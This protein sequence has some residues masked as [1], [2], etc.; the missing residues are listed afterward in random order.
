M[1]IISHST[2]STEKMFTNLIMEFPEDSNSGSMNPHHDA[3]VISLQV[4]NFMIKRVLVDTGSSAN[5]IFAAALADMGAELE[6][7]NR[8]TTV[9]IGFSGEQK[10][11][12]GEITL[13]VYARWINKMTNFLVLDCPSAYNI[14]IGRPWIHRMRVVSS[15]YHQVLKFPTKRGIQEIRGDKVASKGC[16]QTT[17]K[18]KTHSA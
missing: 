10:F 14:I 11:T 4:A 18:A 9:L 17:L 13:P 1:T 12:I 15:T 7:I 8:R 6:K 5:I 3:L 16:Y 2:M